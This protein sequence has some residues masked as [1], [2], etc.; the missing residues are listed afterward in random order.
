[1]T[2]K[3][4]ARRALT[5]LASAHVEIGLLAFCGVIF[6]GTA[7]T[8]GPVFD[9]VGPDLL[10]TV[11]AGMVAALV[12]LQIVFQIVR[13]L[14]SPLPPI[15][16]D[17]IVLRNFVVFTLATG[18]FVLVVARG[19]LPF[20]AATCVFMTVNTMLLS[21]R[22]HWRDAAI[23]AGSGLALGLVLQFTFTRILFV[24]LPG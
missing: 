8:R 18:L 22:L 15:R 4:G 1:M 2:E 21:N 3:T 19:W 9:V 23:G 24:D 12:V 17:S 7:R 16:I 20:A 10:P 11:T 5:I 6:L 14:R 13:A